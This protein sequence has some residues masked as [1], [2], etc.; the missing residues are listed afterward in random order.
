MWRGGASLLFL[1]LLLPLLPS[2]GRAQNSLTDDEIEEFLEGFLKELVP[3]EEEEDKGEPRREEDEEEGV[4][5]RAE[6][7]EEREDTKV[8]KKTKAA[9]G[10]DGESSVKAKEKAKKEKKEKAPK[11]T[12]K[13]K[14]KPPKK[15]KTPKPTKKPKEKKPKPTKKPKEKPPKPTKKPTGKKQDQHPDQGRFSKPKVTVEEER[16]TRTKIEEEEEDKGYSRPES[17]DDYEDSYRRPPAT[18]REREDRPKRPHIP[19]KEED[20]RYRRPHGSVVEEEEGYKE[21]HA[22][23]DY[24]YERYKIPQV[25]E[26]EDKYRTPH[27]AKDVENK[28][29]T[30][31]ITEQDRY[32]RPKV[33]EEEDRYGRPSVTDSRTPT[34]EDVCVAGGYVEHLPEPEEPDREDMTGPGVEEEPPTEDYNERLEREDYDDY[35][36]SKQPKKPAVPERKPDR[37]VVYV[38]PTP[39]KPEI[40]T[41]AT[42]PPPPE[43]PYPRPGFNYDDYDYTT[44]LKPP[45][46]KEEEEWT[47][48]EKYSS[49]KPQKPTSSK[50]EREREEEEERKRKE[51]KKPTDTWDSEEEE[52]VPKERKKCPPIGME[53]HR[54]EDDQILASTMLRHGL[55]AQR[56]RLNMQAGTNE[57]DFYD[58]A[59]CAEDESLVQWLEVDTRRTTLFTG[60]ITQGR[61]SLI[62]DDF[63]T[64]FYVGFSNDSQNWVIY[65]NGYENMMFYGNVDKDTPVQTDFPDPMRARFIR[66]YPQTWNGSLCMRLEVLGCPISNVVSYYSQN[67]VITS[68]DNLDFRH[69]NYKDMRQL[70]K[71]VNE[72]C[73]TITRIYNVGKTAKGLKIYAMEISD[74]PG[75]HE[76]GEPEFRYTA[77]LHGNEVL[78]RELLLLLM[79]FMCKEYRDGNPRIMTLVHETRIHLVPS[80]NP[81]GY[82]IATQMGSELGN[83]ALGHWTEEGYDIFTNFPD[84]NTGFWAAEDRKWVPHRVPNNNLPIPEGFL[85][86]DATVAVE[87]RAIIAWMER[88]PF[89]LGAN[90]QGGEKLVS[91]PYDMAR[92]VKEEE[93]EQP[94]FR[95]HHLYDEDEEEE[96]QM[97]E[98]SGEDDEG[99]SRTTDHSI[100]RWLA[101]SY[102]SAHLNMGNIA[103][104]SCH[105]DDYTKG[106]GIANGGKWRPVS[107]SMNDFSYLHTNCLE[108][109]IYLGC[110]KFPHESEL[111]EEWE[112]NKEALLAFM[113]QVHRGI[114]GIVTDR[115]GEPIANATISLAEINHDVKT[116]AGGDYWRILNPGE[117]RVTAKADGYTQS[118]K[119]CS[120]GY[121]I[122]ATHCNFVLA[123]SNWKRIKE[124]IALKGRGPLRLVPPGGRKLTPEQKLRLQRRRMWLNR[125][126][127]LTTTLP[128]TTTPFE[129]TTLPP[130]DTPYTPTTMPPR[131]LEPPTPSES[132]WDTETETYTEIVTEVETETWEEDT[133]TQVAPFTTA[134]TYTVNFGDF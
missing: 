99:V 90:F 22:P 86:E 59:W 34:G 108:L 104:G 27:A 61:D 123:R 55:H 24:D 89:V 4:I 129:P 21:P 68:S 65:S 88:N 2:T 26:A 114:K 116:A 78:G 125:Q 72:E 10:E 95:P 87:T 102:A 31:V 64:S 110:D 96:E 44:F 121:D 131:R 93:E 58:G 134:E 94:I 45:E 8:G 132:L 75:E 17:A 118:T 20:V 49:K 100:F 120:V 70:M 83:W 6:R 69:H 133:T 28:F 48:E 41:S 11:P 5:T 47:D 107:G 43:Y 127:N 52:E 37:P 128:P 66:I 40:V 18:G 103:R 97:S 124:I 16:H 106:M 3:E 109:S 122:G 117:Y 51:K 73:P 119:T 50:E 36:Y 1:S 12:K 91:Y 35:G 32:K 130:T 25:T 33:T 14:E 74:N 85:A 63:V 92:A 126:R 115:H 71:V 57:D 80:L 84:L 15:E 82:E 112:T 105:A 38:K 79:Q 30:P 42:A 81:D 56:G 54:I 76:I 46:E 98:V 29:R 62:H 77:G 67:E 60:I 9:K 39:K 23:E 101:I 13:P 19:G 113:E 7:Y 111:A 53:S